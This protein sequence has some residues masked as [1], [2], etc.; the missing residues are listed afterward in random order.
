[1]NISIVLAWDS[2]KSPWRKVF[3]HGFLADAA[4]LYLERIKHFVP[5]S[6]QTVSKTVLL[7]A[8]PKLQ[9]Q[10]WMCDLPRKGVGEILSSEQIA[11]KLEK[12]LNSGIGELQ[13][14]IGGPDG[15]SARDHEI[16]KPQLVWSFGPMTLPHELAAV[17]ALEQIYR[18]FSINRGLPYH[19]GH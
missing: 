4:D 9:P 15:W 14:L 19:S 16:L 3:K 8:K 10:R 18:A 5:T 13:I 11:K 7:E 6:I 17:V 12:T 2:K 1:V